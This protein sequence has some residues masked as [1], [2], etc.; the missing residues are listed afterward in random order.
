MAVY[1]GDQ[2][3]GARDLGGPAPGG[4]RPNLRVTVITPGID[5]TGFADDISNPEVR[6][7]IAASKTDFGMP[8]AAIAHAMAYAIAQPPEVDVGEVIVRPTAQA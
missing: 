6:A 4:R 1:S 7:Q 3:G 5:H 2:D 8:P